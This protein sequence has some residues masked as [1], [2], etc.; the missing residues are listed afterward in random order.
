MFYI[1]AC[2]SSIFTASEIVLLKGVISIFGRNKSCSNIFLSSN[3]FVYESSNFEV[4]TISSASYFFGDLCNSLTNDSEKFTIHL[5][6]VTI[7]CVTL[8][9]NNY[10]NLLSAY[11]LAMFL[12]SVTSLKVATLHSSLLKIKLVKV[13][14]RMRC[15]F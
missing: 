13:R 4:V 12:S 9:V 7:S 10:N 11:I 2:F 15:F 14:W 3:S 1:F 5:S 6:G 8:D